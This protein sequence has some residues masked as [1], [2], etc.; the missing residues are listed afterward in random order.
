ME[1]KIQQKED[2][3]NSLEIQAKK[4]NETINDLNKKIIKLTEELESLIYVVLKRPKYIQIKNKW[5]YFDRREKCCEDNCVNTNTPT[6]KCKNGNGFIEII[7]DTDIEYN[8]CI[9]GKGE[10]KHVH[11]NAENKFYKPKNDCNFATL[12]YY[13]EIKIKKEGNGCSSF[14]FRNTEEYTVLGNNGFIWYKSPSNTAEISFEI[15]SFSWNDGD[16]FGCGLVFPPTKMLEKHPY[17]FFTQNGDQIGKA[18][19]LKEESD[20]YFNCYASLKCL[21][22]ETNFGNDLETKPFCFDISKHLFTE[23]FHN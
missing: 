1:E 8:E 2:K 6:G 14:G 4:G 9:E 19:L 23:E 5:K 20:D 3:I 18:V 21:S 10:N 22:I 16:I 13:Y 7:N 17:V 15:P 11:L 12:F